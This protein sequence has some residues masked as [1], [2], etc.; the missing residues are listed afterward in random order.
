M[1][2]KFIDQF[3][4]KIII[5]IFRY[6]LSTPAADRS[7]DRHL[8][9]TEHGCMT[10]DYKTPEKNDCTYVSATFSRDFSR[11]SVTCSG[12][13]PSTTRVFKTGEK[14]EKYWEENLTLRAKIDAVNLPQKR[15]FHVPV[16]GGF[17]ATV[18]MFIPA[19]LDWDAKST[20]VHPMLVRVYGGPGSVRVSS[21]FGVGFHSYQVSSKGVIYV[22]I[23]GRGT[24]QKGNDMMFSVNNRLGTF[25]MD[26]QIAV[27]EYLVNKYSFI[28][29]KRVG[30]WGW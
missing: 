19:G 2:I 26:D 14:N 24:G 5:F 3:R 22:E 7:F 16:Q 17:Q 8:Y 28:D 12:P 9:S 23:D 6:Y 27:A 1:L 10:C 18:M 30:I 21:A 11:Y 13:D 20:T 29:P 15:I 4:L 25:E